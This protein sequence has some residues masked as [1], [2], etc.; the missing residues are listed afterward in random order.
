[1]RV[2]DREAGAVVPEFVLVLLV[3]IPVV[4]A[5]IHVAL[6]MHVRNT[7]T[8]AASDGARAGAAR[9]SSPD[10][11]VQRTR[12]LIGT[13]IADRFASDV[14]AERIDRDGL[15]LLRVTVKTSVPP[16]GVVGPGT[17]VTATAHAVLQDLE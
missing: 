9:G 15:R 5:M 6:V 11:A 13:A 7:V 8:S 17:D 4:A 12:T 1:M 16:L 14:T 3:L 2:S 10:I